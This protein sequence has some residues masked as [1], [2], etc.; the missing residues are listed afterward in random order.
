MIATSTSFLTSLLNKK[1]DEKSTSVC[2]DKD[3]TLFYQLIKPSLNSLV[4]EPSSAT[5]DK[6]LDYSKSL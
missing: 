4:K 3:E 5:I 1:I 2:L 6:I